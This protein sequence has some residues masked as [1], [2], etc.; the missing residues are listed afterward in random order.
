[1][2]KKIKDKSLELS[3]DANRKIRRDWGEIKPYSRIEED[4]RKKK[5]KHKKEELNCD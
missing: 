5:P 2:K 4:K 1:M 3:Y